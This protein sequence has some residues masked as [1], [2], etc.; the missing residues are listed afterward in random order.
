MKEPIL[1]REEAFK[2]AQRFEATEDNDNIPYVVALTP[3]EL[4]QFVSAILENLCGEPIYQLRT[5]CGHW[6]DCGKGAYEI[7]RDDGCRSENCR[8]VYALNRS[9]A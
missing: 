5:G 9:K 2:L 7:A 1:S 4:E 3:L 8:V 6:L